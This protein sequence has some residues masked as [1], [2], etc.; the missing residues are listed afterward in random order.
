[1]ASVSPPR[2]QTLFTPS[3]RR[4]PRRHRGP[5]T[6]NLGWLRPALAVAG[7]VVIVVAG[8]YGLAQVRDNL[9]RPMAIAGDNV[10]PIPGL[11]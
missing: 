11:V 9:G 8:V 7:A 6:S 3:P 10:K 5:R 4:N 1:M 2:F